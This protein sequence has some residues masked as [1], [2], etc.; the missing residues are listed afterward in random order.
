MGF[1]SQEKIGDKNTQIDISQFQKSWVQRI[2]IPRFQKSRICG[3]K[4]AVPNVGDSKKPNTGI[5]RIF[6]CS[7][8]WKIPIQ[9]LKDKDSEF[10]LIHFSFADFCQPWKWDVT[11][12]H[13]EKKSNFRSRNHL[14]CVDLR[15]KIDR[16]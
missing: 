9:N 12:L 2:K 15:V 8:L 4:I 6:K 5:S 3:R 13:N 14:K 11:V 1:P 7:L 16:A 10:L